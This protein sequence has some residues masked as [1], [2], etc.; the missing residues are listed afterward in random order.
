M[1]LD[2][3]I[4]QTLD[5]KASD[6]H[7]HIKKDQVYARWRITG[8]LTAPATFTNGH[9]LANRIKI[10]AKLNVAETRRIQEGQFNY[11]YNGY[12]YCI[13]VSV[14][15][16]DTGEKFALR[17][18]TSSIT[19]RLDE[20]G[21]QSK[22][23]NALK[24]A[25]QQP[26]GLI[27]VCGAT[28][29]GKTTTLYSCLDEIDDGTR[30]IFTIEDPVEIPT[31]SLY[32]FEPNHSL[33][34]S[35]HDLLKA[36]MRQDP[37]VIMVGEIRDAKTAD[38]AIAAALTGHL[39]FATLHTNSALNVV[40]R[41]KNWNVDYFAFA[42]TIK[43]IIHQSMGYQDGK[44]SPNFSTLQPQ[45]YEQLPNSYDALIQQTELWQSLDE[46]CS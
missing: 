41:C 33:E 17:V 37:D 8:C 45:W 31:A 22:A 23:L 32:Q 43:L 19:K 46:E 44:H 42:S 5:R 18:L 26:N 12:S 34:I 6:L 30:A 24:D 38:L 21:I 13:R 2:Q 28:G 15:C 3:L 9:T 14:M 20:L 10:I 29:S 36:L 35:T 27:L 4:A 25:I 7:L 16:S 40:H 11:I 39:V 1:N